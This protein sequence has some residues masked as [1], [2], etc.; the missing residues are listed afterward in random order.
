MRGKRTGRLQQQPRKFPC[1]HCGK[2]FR[3]V[4]RHLNHRESKCGSW[5]TLPPPPANFASP[6]PEAMD[7]M[8]NMPPSPPSTNPEPPQ[9]T[10]PDYSH[11]QPFCTEFP[12]AGKIHGL[13][14][15]F[16]DR[17]QNDKYASFRVQNPYYPFA[18]KDEWELGSFL[19][20]SGMSMQKVDEFLKLKLVLIYFGCPFI[21]PADFHLD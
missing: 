14:E 7:D 9:P 3:D 16:V 21:P 19:L 11:L 12:A 8:D 1:P 10:T 13:A 6:P 17:L 15:S 5:F 4:L 20:S 2:R 18:D